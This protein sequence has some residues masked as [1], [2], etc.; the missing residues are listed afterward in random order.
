M[1]WLILFLLTV[2]T[3]AW[4]VSRL[5]TGEPDDHRLAARARG[6]AE[7]QRYRDVY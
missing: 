4:W 6:D 7:A 3:L 2:A 1:L 5:G